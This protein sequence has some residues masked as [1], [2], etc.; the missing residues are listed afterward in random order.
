MSIGNTIANTALAGAAG[1]A[2]NLLLDT[3]EAIQPEKASIMGI[4][5]FTGQAEIPERD[6]QWWPESLTDDIAGG[7][8]PVQ[9]PGGSHPLMHW[10]SLGER[11]FSFAAVLSRELL[12]SGDN[13]S[14]TPAQV[15]TMLTGDL[16]APLVDDSNSRNRAYNV[17]ISERIAHLRAF[18]YPKYRG[19]GIGQVKPPP[20]AVLYMPNMQLNEDGRDTIW[21]VMRSCS[22]QYL[23]AFPNGRPRLA[24]VTLS[25]TQVVQQQGAVRWR[26]RDV[27]LGR[28]GRVGTVPRTTLPPPRGYES[29]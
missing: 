5:P 1:L 25:F 29:P 13:P 21:T 15:V 16:T 2:A 26:G 24:V 17:D 6:F 3:P 14:I 20:I 7:W 19:N 22:V 18:L 9:I 11:T 28:R 4:D 10:S 23:R 27:L 12:M 8:Q